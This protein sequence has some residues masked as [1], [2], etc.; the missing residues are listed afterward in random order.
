M[1]FLVNLFPRAGP[2]AQ[3]F[4]DQVADG[5]VRVGFGTEIERLG[6]AGDLRRI[7]FSARLLK[8]CTEQ[9]IPAERFEDMLPGAGKVRIA[10]RD[11]FSLRQGADAIGHEAVLG[12][13][14]AADD[15][16]RAGRGE[17]DLRAVRKKGIA[18][19]RHDDFR[20]R[21][22]RTVGIVTAER[23]ALLEAAR[24][25]A[26]RSTVVF[27]ALVGRDDDDGAG[28]ISHAHR[29]KEMGR[30][31]RVGGEGRHRLTIR[32]AHQRLRGEVENEVGTDFG[33]LRV[34]GGSVAD[35]EHV[36]L[37]PPG[38]VQRLEERR[39]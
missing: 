33:Y 28:K 13:V 35:V 21:L 30:A 36:V 37:H 23:I 10:H 24:F 31:K 18:I 1:F 2:A 5:A 9:E 38:Q 20:R 15:V 32:N 27:V 16:A 29:F 19:R 25:T 4:L 17:R 22:A 14:A 26:V 7:F 11:R 6:V 3:D 34:Q 12:P 39:R 8:F